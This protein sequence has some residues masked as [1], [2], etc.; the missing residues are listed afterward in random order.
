MATPN[1]DSQLFVVEWFDPMPMMK[2][3]YLLKYYVDQHMVEMVDVKSKKMFLRKSP[4]PKEISPEEFFIGSKIAIYSRELEIVDYGDKKTRERLHTQ[5]QQCVVILPQSSVERWGKVIEGF[6]GNMLLVRAKSVI[7]SASQA[8]NVCQVLDL[9]LSNSGD[10]SLGV[11]LVLVFHGPDGFKRV[12]DIAGSSGSGA[13]FY[14]ARN[15]A[16]SSELQSTLLDSRD[17][18]PTATFDSCTCCVVKPHAVKA[19]LFGPILTQ[20]VAQGYEVSA[21][22]S[23][24]FE[25]KQ[26]EE[27]LQVYQGVVPDF[28]DHVTQMCLGV[29][30]AL[31]IRAQEAVSTFRETAG[32]WQVEYAKELRP[33]SIRGMFGVEGVRNAVHC[34]DL[35][36]DGTLECEYVFK[37]MKQ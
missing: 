27:F 15:G 28:A 23:L 5:V 11:T 29:S 26:A 32:P 14:A 8:D 36:Q 1:D 7:L 30:I 25:R 12:D 19:A 20:I 13:G 9:P 2:K 31:E 21:V 33:Q 18:L 16:Q 17:I 3:T 37:V 6:N 4:C 10:L 24:Q 35:P 22:R 34:T